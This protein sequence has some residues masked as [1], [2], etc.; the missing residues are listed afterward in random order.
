MQGVIAAVPTALDAQGDFLPDLFLSHCQWALENGCDGLNILGSTGEANS[1]DTPTRLAVM[2]A[3]A[4][5]LETSRLMVGTGTPSLA[6]TIA[7]TQVAD[8]LGYGV[9]LVLPP[10]YY[11]P[12]SDEY[13]VAWYEKLHLSLGDRPISIY[14]YNFPQMTGIGLPVSVIQTL[15]SRWPT[16]YRGIKDSS[17]DLAYCRELAMALPELR[18]FPSSEVSLY[19]AYE[20]R[21]SGCIS[22]TTNQTGVLAAR[23]WAGRKVPDQ[24]LADEIS[25]VREVIAGP[26]LVASVKY[27]VACR[28]GQSDWENMMPPFM[29]LS[30]ERKAVLAPTVDLLARS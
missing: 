3:S 9:A 24:A 16:R 22:A 13:L 26:T 2:R 25:E 20:S 5:S 6:E 8:D 4:E 21:F 27:L 12:L 19:E 18:V 23:L 28:S 14:F 1:L 15:H 30:N 11:K 29:S 10:Y 7:L 17:G